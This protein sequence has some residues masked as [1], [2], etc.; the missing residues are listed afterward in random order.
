[1]IKRTV[2][3]LLIGL[4]SMVGTGCIAEISKK[5]ELNQLEKQNGY[6]VEEI[7]RPV[8]PAISDLNNN[9]E[10]SSN[11]GTRTYQYKENDGIFVFY[12]TDDE[13]LYR[14]LLPEEFDMPDDL[15]VHIFVMDFY[16]IDSEADPYKEMSM[17]L[18]AKHNGE[19]I[20]HC[21]YMPVTSQ[22]SMIAGR[23]GLGLPKTMGDIQFTRDIFTYTGTVI[24]DQGRSGT[25]AINTKDYNMP[26]S[27]EAEIKSFMSLPKVNLLDGDFVQMTRAGGSVNIID[28]A[29]RYK[30]LVTL[31]GGLAT[32][33]FDTSDDNTVHPFDLEPSEIIAAYFLHNEIPFS[34]DRVE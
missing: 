25:I 8:D 13:E 32:I 17:S 10:V 34:L 24:D 4:M 14:K 20:W 33:S 21:I 6:Q 16:D 31:Q 22:Q 2:A 3:I 11:L 18:L 15:V 26:A 12:E 23:I 30:R 28:V 19:D 1:M 29:N 5:E 27:E 7:E 9:I